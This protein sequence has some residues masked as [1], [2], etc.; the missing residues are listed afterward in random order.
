M[1]WTQLDLAG[2]PADV[3][4]P[5]G[6]SLRFGVLFLHPASFMLH[7]CQALGPA[8]T[9]LFDELNLA[10]LC[11]HGGLSWWADRLCPDFDPGR[12]AERYLLDSVVPFFAQHWKLGPRAI[13][14]LGIEMGGQG[15]L[16]LAF[17]YPDRFPVVSA[18][19]PAI[20]YDRLYGRGSPLDEMYDS[21]EQCRQD[22]ALLH[23]HPVQ[24]P[25]HLFFCAHPADPDWYRGCDRLHEKLSALGV[26]HTCDLTGPAVR[27]AEEYEEHMAERAVRFLV[28]GLEQE[29]RR[30]L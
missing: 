12:T 18:I 11:P 10:C 29:S 20:E 23:I 26:A 7:P 2:H 27:S 1:I 4:A 5:P 9:R 24:Q 30:L 19:S 16:R 21:K 25:P 3:Y 6:G 17:K 13:G 22:T 8:F 14:L 28:A 15:A